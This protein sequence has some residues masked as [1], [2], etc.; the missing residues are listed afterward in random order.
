MH[1]RPAR[2]RSTVAAALL[3][4]CLTS[5]LSAGQRLVGI[6]GAK[7]WPSKFVSPD[8]LT[9]WLCFADDWV[10]KHP[11]DPPG[12]RYGM[13]LHETKLLRLEWSSPQTIGRVLFVRSAE[14]IR[15]YHRR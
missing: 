2:F 14:P 4:F 12:T 3:L 15:L 9:L 8:G 10:R 7:L 11:S 6:R 13:C 5:R 1:N